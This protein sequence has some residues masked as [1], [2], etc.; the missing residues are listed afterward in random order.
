MSNVTIFEFIS[1]GVLDVT[2][3]AKFTQSTTDVPPSQ[4]PMI[5]IPYTLKAWIDAMEIPGCFHFI[6]SKT[7]CSHRSAEKIWKDEE[8]RRECAWIKK[9]SRAEKKKKYTDRNAKQV[10]ADATHSTCKID[11]WE[12]VLGEFLMPF[13]DGTFDKNDFLI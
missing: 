3:W 13:L 6:G 1:N 11:D 12:H 9:A 10:F 5:N 8:K 2:N 7:H 4:K